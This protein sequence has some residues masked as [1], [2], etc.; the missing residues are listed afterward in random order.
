MPCQEV[1]T[2]GVVYLMEQTRNAVAFA[3]GLIAF[4]LFTCLA[5]GAAFGQVSQVVK[6][7]YEFAVASKVLPAGTYTFSVA[8]GANEWLQVRSENGTQSRVHI[9]TRLG[10]PSAFMQDGSLVFD[11]SS[12]RHILCEVWIPGTDGL[13]LRRAPNGTGR[14]IVLLS[15]LRSTANLSGKAAY[16]RTCS[17]CHGP[18]GKGDP[19]ADKFFNTA[20]PKLASER[21]QGKSDA[22]MRE[23]ITKGSS[24][25]PPV[26][27]DESGYRHRLSP[28]SVDAVITHVRTFKR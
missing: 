23:I 1:R 28:E 3:K 27:I 2:E 11:K 8:T 7:P 14:E 21:V 5:A 22:E 18:D 24:A 19:K 26:E 25:M 4:S 17:R 9:M 15:D 6:I 20:I 12:G 10:G 13:L 16:D